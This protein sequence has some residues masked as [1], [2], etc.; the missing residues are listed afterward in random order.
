MARPTE[1]RGAL[2][3]RKLPPPDPAMQQRGWAALILAVL[4]LFGMSQLGNLHRGVYVIIVTL[5]IALCAVWLGVSALRRARRS[6]T[7]RPR[8]AVAGTVLGGIGLVFSMLILVAFAMFWKEL[9]AYSDCLASASTPSA[10]QACQS[11]FTHSVRNQL[12]GRHSGGG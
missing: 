2:P 6:G 7:A 12:D 9:A 10:Q 5:L 11:Q 3:A 1:Q 4:S 8:G